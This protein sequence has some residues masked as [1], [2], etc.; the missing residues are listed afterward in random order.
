MTATP[1]AAVRDE[2]APVDLLVV[3][4]PDGQ[5]TA[6]G[7]DRL[8]ALEQ[9]GTIRILDVEFVRMDAD[10]AVRRVDAADLTAPDGLALRLWS[11]ASAALLDEEDLHG[12]EP[13]LEP[14]AVAVVVVYENRWVLDIVDAWRAS[15]ARLVADGGLSVAALEAALDDT[16][17]ADDGGRS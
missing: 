11:G 12:L 7:L 8:L 1:A 2:L 13:D 15:G 10:G 9:A 6:P 17:P 16:E 3:S 14:G 4:F 5:V